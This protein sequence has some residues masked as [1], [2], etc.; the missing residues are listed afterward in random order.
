M[1]QISRSFMDKSVEI[2]A[3]CLK[4]IDML[5][6]RNKVAGDPMSFA[7]LWSSLN[8]DDVLKQGLNLCLLYLCLV[9]SH[10]WWYAL[11]CCHWWKHKWNFQDIVFDQICRCYT[12]SPFLSLNS[13]YMCTY[14]VCVLEVHTSLENTAEEKREAF[15]EK[16]K[17]FF[18]SN[19]FEWTWVLV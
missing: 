3:K 9:D 14:S 2:S 6:S 1:S 10:S 13:W 15:T 11:L 16:W 5:G 4:Y 18:S 12:L 7:A 17:C 19:V 8:F